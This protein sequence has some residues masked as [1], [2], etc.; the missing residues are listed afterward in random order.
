MIRSGER[1]EARTV[2]PAYLRF[3]EAEIRR[4]K[5]GLAE[6]KIDN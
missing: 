1:K 4:R 5:G 2:V 3:S 6:P